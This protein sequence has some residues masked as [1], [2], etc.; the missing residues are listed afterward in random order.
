MMT[1]LM[2]T[3]LRT[4]LSFAATVAFIALAMMPARAVEGSG[5]TRDADPVA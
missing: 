4:K 5:A 1:D 3:D 2:M